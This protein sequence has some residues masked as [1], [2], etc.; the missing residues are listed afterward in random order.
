MIKGRPSE[1]VKVVAS[2]PP[3][4]LD[5]HIDTKFTDFK[6]WLGWMNAPEIK[7]AMTAK[8]PPRGITPDTMQIARADFDPPQERD[9]SFS[10]RIVYRKPGLA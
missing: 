4:E 8:H 7:E 9:S 5:A 2:I 3:R 1:F 6:D 10:R